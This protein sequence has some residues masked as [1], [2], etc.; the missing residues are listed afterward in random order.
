[1]WVAWFHVFHCSGIVHLVPD[2]VATPLPAAPL[3]LRDVTVTCSSVAYTIIFTLISRNL[4]TALYMLR[5]DNMKALSY[6]RRL[7]AGVLP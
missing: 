6:L 3:L 1:M 4:V 2:R 5:Y 7:D